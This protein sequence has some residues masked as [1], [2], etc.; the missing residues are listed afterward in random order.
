MSH[1]KLRE[2]KQPLC[3]GQLSALS[4]SIVA[5]DAAFFIIIIII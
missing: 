5:A 4:L 2:R 1:G 3:H